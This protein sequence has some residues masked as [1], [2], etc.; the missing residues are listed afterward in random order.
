MIQ[1]VD[2]S[3][4]EMAEVRSLSCTEEVIILAVYSKYPRI[5]QEPNVLGSDLCIRLMLWRSPA[6]QTQA[7]V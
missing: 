1:H 2:I 3:Q 7:S 5:G 6:A 4:D